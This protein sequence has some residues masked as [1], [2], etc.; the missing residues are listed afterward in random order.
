MI[1]CKICNHLSVQNFLVLFLNKTSA[2]PA[3]TLKNQWTCI[4]SCECYYDTTQQIS[5][6]VVCAPGTIS[7]GL[8]F[9]HLHVCSIPKTITCKDVTH[10]K[11][12]AIR[13]RAV[14]AQ[15]SNIIASGLCGCTNMWQ[16]I[17][18][19]VLNV[20]SYVHRYWYYN[21]IFRWPKI[22]LWGYDKT[23]YFKLFFYNVISL[24]LSKFSFTLP[25]HDGKIFSIV[26][27]YVKCFR[28][29]NVFLI[30]CINL[31]SKQPTAFPNA[32]A[33]LDAIVIWY[34]IL[35]THHSVLTYTMRSFP[36]HY[37]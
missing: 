36:Q 13:W 8:S 21:F 25:K 1:T 10:G 33:V 9:G 34:L 18:L 37:F 31:Q 15:I 27:I 2:K 35:L 6:G 32:M 22:P 29:G 12:E 28:N 14:I 17:L 4:T 20:S 3:M 11:I 30:V 19:N 5:T 7:F 23:S 24:K 26:P 16:R